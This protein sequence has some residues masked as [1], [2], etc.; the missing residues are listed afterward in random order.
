MES[1]RATLE[2]DPGLAA[3]HAGMG[4]TLFQLQRYEAA[5]E[6]MGKAVS[7]GLDPQVEGPI[8]CLMGQAWLHLERPRQAEEYFRRAIEIDPND[9]QAIDHPA[10]LSFEREDYEG[11]RELYVRLVGLQPGS[12][13]SL[14][15]LAAALYY[16]GRREEAI[17]GFERALALDPDLTTARTALKQLRDGER[18]R[19]P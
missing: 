3:A 12:P 5:K 14:S 7:L 9:T 15:N 1:Y 4:D 11:A 16:L 8:Q 6:A 13:Q 17:R 2:A 19:A 18:R 10:K